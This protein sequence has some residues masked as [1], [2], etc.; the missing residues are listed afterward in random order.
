MVFLI[1]FS[2]IFIYS[3]FKSI[4]IQFLF[5]FFATTAVVPAPIKGSKTIPFAKGSLQSHLIS[6]FL[7]F[8]F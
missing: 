8:L 4:P 5:N 6:C 3:G 7:F 1:R 2:A